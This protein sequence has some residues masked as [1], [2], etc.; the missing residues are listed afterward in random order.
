MANALVTGQTGNQ[1]F[2]DEKVRDPGVKALMEKIMVA[3]DP[4]MKTLE[5][6][7]EMKTKGGK[8]YSAFTDVLKEIPHWRRKG[9]G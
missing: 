8:V 9:S 6:R 7:V 3:L 1:A 4:E 5:S 2:T